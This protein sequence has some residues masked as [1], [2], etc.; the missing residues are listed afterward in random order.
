LAGHGVDRL[1]GCR[2]RLS[3][4][5]LETSHTRVFEWPGC[6]REWFDLMIRDQ[7]ALGRLDHVEIV[8][9]RKLASPQSWWVPTRVIAQG[10]EPPP[11]R[12]RY[13]HSKGKQ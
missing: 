4:R 5:Q 8:F 1:R 6:G 11:I 7:L 3:V 10:V 12:A 2:Y 13:E 9:G